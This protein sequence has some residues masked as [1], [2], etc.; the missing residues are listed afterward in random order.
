MT[1]AEQLGI[2]TDVTVITPC[3]VI[4]D[5]V[6]LPSP[7]AIHMYRN[8]WVD[9]GYPWRTNIGSLLGELREKYGDD[10]D[11]IVLLLDRVNG[12]QACSVKRGA[13]EDVKAYAE[14]FGHVAYADDGK[15]VAVIAI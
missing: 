14:S 8:V 1:I 3:E 4:E 6:G 12:V 5:F 13:V 7:T 10:H 15:L 11:G 2:T 9:D